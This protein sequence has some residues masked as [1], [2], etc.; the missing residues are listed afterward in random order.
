MDSDLLLK[1]VAGGLCA[2]A[3]GLIVVAIIMSRRRPGGGQNAAPLSRPAAPKPSQPYMNLP[4]D[5]GQYEDEEMPTV[6]VAKPGALPSTPR[7]PGSNAPT[8]RGG[9]TSGS[10]IIAFD[11]DDEDED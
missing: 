1:L 5:D 9:H 10:T 2:S 3:A 8:R 11:D 4:T 6:I 7:P